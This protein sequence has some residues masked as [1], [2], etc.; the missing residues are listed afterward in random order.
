MSSQPSDSSDDTGAGDVGLTRASGEPQLKGRTLPPPWGGIAGPL[1]VTALTLEQ[2]RPGLPVPRKK[3][4]HAELATLEAQLRAADRQ[5]DLEAERRAATALSRALAAR[6]SEL[7]TATKLARRAL[8]LGDDASLRTEL[9]TWFAGLGE[10]A[11]AAATLRPM[12]NDRSGTALSRLLTR[13]AVLLA[14][15]GDAAGAARALREA[16]EQADTDPL[17]P[18]LMGAVGAWAPDSLPAESAALA[19]VEGSR[20]RERAGEKSAAFED[21]LRAF[22]AAPQCAEAANALHHELSERGRAGAA[23]E[24][25]REHARVLLDEQARAVHLVRME[26]AAD[27]GELHRGIAAGLDARLESE[28]NVRD[29]VL[30]AARL[31]RGEQ[32]SGFDGLLDEVGLHD[33]RAARL[34]VAADSLEGQSRAAARTAAARIYSTKLAR[35]TRAVQ[36][37]LDAVVNHPAERD[38]WRGLREHAAQT[39]DFA[40]LVEGLI[41]VTERVT[42]SEAW[43]AA[44][45][46]LLHLAEERLSDPGLAAWAARR[47]VAQ[48]ATHVEARQALER[49]APRVRLQNET[50]KSAREQL[51]R[52]P[53]DL[54]LLA[55]LAS[56]LLGRPDDVQETLRVLAALVELAPG[57]ARWRGQYRLLLERAGDF[58]KLEDF[59]DDLAAEAHSPEKEALV[60]DRARLARGRRDFERALLELKPWLAEANTHTEVSAIGLVLAS[61]VRDER[62]RAHALVRMAAPLRPPLRATLMSI[63]VESLL[64]AGDK[65][66]ARALAEAAC[67]ADPSRTRPVAARAFAVADAEQPDHAALERAV[68]VVVPR[69]TICAAIA[70]AYENTGSPLLAL[71][72]TQRQ[73]ALR[74]GDLAVAEVLL[75][76]VIEAGD[77]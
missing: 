20:R 7:D 23:D 6:G 68:G 53:E 35:P 41:R 65:T 51:A 33:L 73:L 60:L 32:D 57:Q 11:L 48:Q 13:I 17:P 5:G 12:L 1:S 2:Q 29:A 4:P 74:P 40:P 63:A 16:T 77:A 55:R 52:Q 61:R 15:A 72:W 10:P 59:L 26:L 47:L 75:R 24:V 25:L 38:A 64:A 30:A 44:A 49:L 70:K 27:Q 31:E 54:Q 69:T 71:A 22:E 39:M 46:E 76:R 67:H 34:E 21:L 28:F 19:Y 18:E 66:D 62:A 45:E 42:D 14:R 3:G 8:V 37:W 58:Q 9:S 56:V 50:L 43:G 36:A